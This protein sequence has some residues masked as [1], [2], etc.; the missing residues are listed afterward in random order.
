[1]KKNNKHFIIAIAIAFVFLVVCSIKY[2]S[3]S[4]TTATVPDLS[5]AE[6]FSALANVSMS[7]DGGGFINVSG[8]FGLSPGLIGAKTGNWI[9]SDRGYFGDTV[10]D[11]ATLAVDESLISS[12][13]QADALSAYNNLV[14][15][16]TSGAW[17]NNHNPVPGVWTEVGDAVFNGVLTLDGDYND[18]WVFQISGD[19]IFNGSVVM[20]GNAQPCNVFFQVGGD[21]NIILGGPVALKR[22]FFS[23]SLARASDLYRFMGTIIGSGDIVVASLNTS[24]DGRF[25]SLN[26]SLTL[27]G[28]HSSNISGP[29]C[30]VAPSPQIT[31]LKTIINDNGGTATITDWTLVATGP[32]TVSG[33]SGDASITDAT[34]TFGTYTLSESGGPSGYTASEYSCVVNSGSAVVS[35]SLILENGDSAVCTITNDDIFH[36][37]GGGGGYLITKTVPKI[38]TPTVVTPVVE[39]VSVTPIVS[40]VSDVIIPGFPKTGIIGETKKVESMLPMRFRIPKINI[41]TA[42]ESVGI[43]SDGTMGVPKNPANVA[44]FNLGPRPGEIG[45]SVMDGH[46]GYKNKKPV[47]FD[48]LYKLKKGDKIYVENQNGTVVTFVVR[49]SRKYNPKD[50]AKDVFVSNDGKSHLNLI[51]CAGDWDPIIGSHSKR[52]VV[53]TDKEI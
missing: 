8:N 20:A 26:G 2:M 13:A 3:V 49:E 36:S 12:Q 50:S 18:V 40:N 22:N 9:P 43:V 16:T 29:T 17:E 37:H 14:G 1:M 42:I 38:T 4:A 53:F 32:T 31:L 41:N 33:V 27:N 39:P 46:S 19:F 51:T 5:T 35:N 6:N 10:D 15:Q 28:D 34:V 45:S 7:Y 52:L 11:P 25:I 30:T 44:W 48:N 47:V 24:T 21:T 23:T